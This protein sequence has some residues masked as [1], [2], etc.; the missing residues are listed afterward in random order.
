MHFDKLKCKQKG[1]A[2]VFI[3]FILTIVAIIGGVLVY[4]NY[5]NNQTDT[6]PALQAT[7]TPQPT[8]TPN[9]G[10][11]G[12]AP[13]GDAETANWKTY[14]N[15]KYKYRFDYPPEGLIKSIHPDYVEL[16]G[17]RIGF[18]MIKIEQD[19]ID[20]IDDTSKMSFEELAILRARFL[21]DADGPVGSTSCDRVT[22]KQYFINKHGTKV[23]EF[24]LNEISNIIKPDGQSE[25]TNRIVGPIFAIDISKQSNKPARLL[26][27]YDREDLF[28][29]GARV[30]ESIV[31][32]VVD[33]LRF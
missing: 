8:S 27:I 25:H 32:K 10:D 1:F 19:F 30:N 31:R 13:N 16:E 21:C 15:E 23:L 28:F 7:Q 2:Q 9:V 17:D 12:G 18:I 29:I 20:H 3:V 24:Y 22:K 6:T 4:T 5:S 26:L 14:T 33:S 11:G